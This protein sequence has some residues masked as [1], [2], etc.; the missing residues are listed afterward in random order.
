MPK[1]ICG[2][3]FKSVCNYYFHF[4]T[5]S[6]KGQKE[7]QEIE[8]G[9]FIFVNMSHMSS[10]LDTVWKNE[11]K[12]NVVL[13]THQSDDPCPGSFSWL[14]KDSRLLHWYGQNCDLTK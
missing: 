11:I 1:F 8:Y 3:G 5:K 6:L 14:L 9:D 13:V 2:N 7:G 4:P 12:T 10:F